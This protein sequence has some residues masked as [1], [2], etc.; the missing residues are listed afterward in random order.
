[1][2]I[3]L[4]SHCLVVHPSWLHCLSC[5]NHVTRTRSPTGVLRV[6]TKYLTT[7]M[8]SASSRGKN[9]LDLSVFIAEQGRHWLSQHVNNE[10]GGANYLVV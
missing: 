4:T 9:F 6:P 8:R 1:M 7:T 2:L 5:A 10:V 3:W